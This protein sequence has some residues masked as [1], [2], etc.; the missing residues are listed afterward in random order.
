MTLEEK[1]AKFLAD[2]RERRNRGWKE[3]LNRITEAHGINRKIARRACKEHGTVLAAQD[4]ESKSERTYH[5]HKGM[6][7]RVKGLTCENCPR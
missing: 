3:T 2:R 6:R 1:N 7:G 5:Y 4:T